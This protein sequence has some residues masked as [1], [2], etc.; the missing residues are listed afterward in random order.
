M[1][2]RDKMTEETL[3]NAK[4]DETGE[5]I[6]PEETAKEETAP[7]TQEAPEN[8]EKPKKPGLI[9]RIKASGFFGP[10]TTTLFFLT[11]AGLA[12]YIVSR[13]SPGFAEFWT[14][15]PAQ[16]I[17][18]LL[19][20]ATGWIPF[21]LAEAL[22]LCIP[23]IA[24]G[25]II[26]SAVSTKRDGSTKN[27]VRWL[28]PVICVI[29]A[30]VFVFFAAFGPGYGRYTLAE[31]L[32][33]E[34]APVSGQELYDTAV[35]VTKELNPLLAE[36]TF[37]SG[38]ASVMPC[39]YDEMVARVNAAY[40]KYAAGA[41]YVSHF[42][43]YPKP[44]ALSEPMTY[45]HIAGVYTFMTGESNVNT[46]YPDFLNAFTMAHEMSHQRGIAREDEANFVAFLVCS[47]ADDVYVRYCGY[48][49]LLNYLLSSLRSADKELYDSYRRAY[50]PDEIVGEFNS[51]AR[52]FDKYRESTASKVTGAV[53]DAYLKSQNQKAGSKSYGLVVD[54]AV[55]YYKS[56]KSN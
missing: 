39:G 54:L 51:Y 33:L 10:G 56:I 1:D 18:F 46:N 29:F 37:D 42:S 26:G 25:Y 49:N 3:E 2:V 20:K 23:I 43:S 34:S 4:T 12:V 36:V 28:R 15:Y 50:L 38:G 32:G 7:E 53:N 24:V 45:T 35:A 27:Y 16:G 21:S 6:Q 14:R 41:D 48:A 8:G 9:K 40:E 17:R 22:L 52:F 47:G 11:V 55:A 13:F 30:V 44:I 19:A 5:V 31:N